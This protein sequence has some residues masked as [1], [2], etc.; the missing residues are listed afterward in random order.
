MDIRY[1]EG[2][3]DQLL[4]RTSPIYAWR[5]RI[6]TPFSGRDGAIRPAGSL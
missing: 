4:H 6:C 3:F 1:A 2:K 5:R